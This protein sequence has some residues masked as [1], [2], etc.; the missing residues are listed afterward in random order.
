MKKQKV[1][2]ESL[3]K[4]I[5]ENSLYPF[6]FAERILA[7]GEFTQLLRGIYGETERDYENA[8]MYEEAAKEPDRFVVKRK[9]RG[10]VSD[11]FRQRMAESPLN[12]KLSDQSYA[13]LYEAVSFANW[14]G[15]ILNGRVTISWS[16]LGLENEGKARKK[17]KQ[18][19]KNLRSRF[20][21]WWDSD[22]RYLRGNPAMWIYS[23][24]QSER[25]G[26]HTHMMLHMP[27]RVTPLFRNWARS[28]FDLP[29]RRPVGGNSGRPVLIRADQSARSAIKY[30]W[31]RF[32][33]LLKGADYTARMGCCPQTARLISLGDLLPWEHQPMGEIIGKSICGMSRNLA[34]DA[35]EAAGYTAI[36]P[37]R[38]R[39][40][41]VRVLYGEQ[42]YRMGQLDRAMADLDQI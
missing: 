12:R 5:I 32:G 35:R 42:I 30:Q 9:S 6:D 23:H 17:F 25:T 31:L 26:F 10:A 40:L 21:E 18:F 2:S 28:F 7:I 8:L 11:E 29:K 15:A 36:S 27:P 3:A 14:S 16:M 22:Y 38:N 24:E 39:Q 20:D 41:D 13:H 33:Y 37:L 4:E 19:T 1:C 34:W